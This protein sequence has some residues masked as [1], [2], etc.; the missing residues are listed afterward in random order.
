MELFTWNLFVGIV[1]LFLHLS[2]GRKMDKECTCSLCCSYYKDPII[3]PCTD[4]FCS[5]CLI[6]YLELSSTQNGFDTENSFDKEYYKNKNSFECPSCKK[7]AELPASG[8]RGLPRYHVIEQLLNKKIREREGLSFL[9]LSINYLSYG[10]G[11]CCN[12]WLEN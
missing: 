6:K 12:L 3:L 8:L 10:R 7:R 11:G 5:D 2:E 1:N 4:S 9:N